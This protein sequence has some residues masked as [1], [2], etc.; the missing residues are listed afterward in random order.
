MDEM[1]LKQT[2]MTYSINKSNHW[3]RATVWMLSLSL[4]GTVVHKLYSFSSVTLFTW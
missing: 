4:T 3:H 1:S 2:L